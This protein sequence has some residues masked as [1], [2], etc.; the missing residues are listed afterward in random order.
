M[1]GGTDR[2]KQDTTER[3][4]EFTIARAKQ[5]VSRNS[6]AEHA[7]NEPKPAIGTR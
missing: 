5:H 3:A 2:D 1:N 4:Q 7:G 6:K